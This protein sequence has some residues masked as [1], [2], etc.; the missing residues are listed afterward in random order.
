MDRVFLDANVL[1]SA[2]YRS[3][4][5]LVDIWSL[6]ETE[7][8]TSVFALEEA[9]RN[10]VAHRSKAL[11]RLDEL[12]DSLII[13]DETGASLPKDIELVGKDAPILSAAISAKCSHL[14]TGDNRHFGSL[15]GSTV[16]GVL[17]LTP[18]RYLKSRA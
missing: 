3:D 4:S 15:Y 5:R 6:P 11:T 7:L 13:V 10:L 12:S 16:Q 9:R 1:F 17:V 18:S 8:V 2:A 14:I